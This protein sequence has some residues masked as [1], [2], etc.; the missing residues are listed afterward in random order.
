M[1]RAFQALSK[2]IDISFLCSVEGSESCQFSTA[3]DLV[4]PTWIPLTLWKGGSKELDSQNLQLDQQTKKQAELTSSK[5]VLAN[6]TGD[7][8]LHT[9]WYINDKGD[10][11]WLKFDSSSPCNLFPIFESRFY[12]PK[13]H[14]IVK[15]PYSDKKTRD[16]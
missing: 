4:A 14:K 9:A 11:I 3:Q 5:Y 2:F 15:D 16:L 1:G 7:S 13:L 8:P 6:Q 10:K 12:K